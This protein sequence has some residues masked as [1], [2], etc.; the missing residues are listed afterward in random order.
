MYGLEH[1]ASTNVKLQKKTQKKM[2][3]WQHLPDDAR[4]P[5]DSSSPSYK[6]AENWWK[7]AC[8]GLDSTKHHNFTS[9]TVQHN[10]EVLIQFSTQNTPTGL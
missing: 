10:V 9:T 5:I 1:L 7:N 8:S 3:L 2:L 6:K 4:I